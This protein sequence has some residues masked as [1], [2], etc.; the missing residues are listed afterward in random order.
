MR[1]L[2][3]TADLFRCRCDPAWLSDPSALRDDCADVLSR[4]GRAVAHDWFTADGA[5]GVEGSMLFE[6]GRLQLRT[7]TVDRGVLLDL[8]F[9]SASPESARQGRQLVE[10]LVAR[11]APEWTEQR[12]MDRGEDA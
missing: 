3:L 12:S 9:D 5:A 10:A 2:H 8:M 11:L 6:G 1:A 7:W 4:C